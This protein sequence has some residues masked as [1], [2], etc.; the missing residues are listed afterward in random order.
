M[1][2]MR[3]TQSLKNKRLKNERLEDDASTD[4][5]EISE[6]EN[7]TGTTIRS[8]RTAHSDDWLS[9]EKAEEVI[10][11]V[12]KVINS[13]TAMDKKEKADAVEKSRK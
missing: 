1:P 7:Q 10:Y 5:S 8:L 13:K 9:D 2:L 6:D 11:K 12:K 3:Q 4:F